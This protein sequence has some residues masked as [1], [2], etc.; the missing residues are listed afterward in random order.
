MFALNYSTEARLKGLSVQVSRDLSQDRLLLLSALELGRHEYLK[1]QANKGFLDDKDFMEWITG[2]PLELLHPR[3]EPHR[4]EVDDHPALVAIV[5]ESGHLNVNT[6]AQPLLERILNVCGVEPGQQTTM[7]VNSLLDWRDHDDLHRPEGAESDYYL[8]LDPPYSAKNADIQS[9]EELLLVRGVGP[10]LY[11]GTPDRPGLVDFLGVTGQ[12]TIL[13]VNSV[14]PKAF[15]LI[16]GFPEEA[17]Q[18][19]VAVRTASPIADVADLADIVPQAFMSQFVDYFGVV[20]SPR[21]TL[22]AAVL[23][24][25]ESPGRWM[26]MT[27]DAGI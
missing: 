25:D 3:H 15:A 21:V 8:G 10:D 13:D 2:R 23:D 7:I 17:V 24:E 5:F 12:N 27:L 19:I 26:E 6:I 1:Y 22:R 11:H 4:V 18:A 20:E 9:L 14:S 16:D